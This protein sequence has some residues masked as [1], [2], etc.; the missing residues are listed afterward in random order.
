MQT[1]DGTLADRGASSKVLDV[2]T[3]VMVPVQ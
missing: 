3:G 1:V 2:G